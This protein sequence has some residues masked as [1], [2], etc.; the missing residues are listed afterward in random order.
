MYYF[1]SLQRTGKDK[2]ENLCRS[3]SGYK[4]TLNVASVTCWSLAAPLQEAAVY[5]LS[6]RHLLFLTEQQKH[7][8]PAECWPPGVSPVSRHQ[9]IER[10]EREGKYGEMKTD[11]QMLRCRLMLLTKDRRGKSSRCVEEEAP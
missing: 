4:F 3:I 9:I 6:G 8:R 11:S 10:G 7:L 2:K 5:L 1:I